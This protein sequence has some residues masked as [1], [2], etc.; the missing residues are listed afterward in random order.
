MKR[1][2]R[3]PKCHCLVIRDPSIVDNLVDC[4]NESC[5]S[6]FCWI[7]LDKVY[8]SNTEILHHFGEL[9]Y[10]QCPGR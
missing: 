8:E 4:P 1:P 5:N 6:K 10:A 9:N 3:C 7:C 2:V